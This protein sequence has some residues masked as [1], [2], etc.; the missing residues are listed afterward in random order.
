[1]VQAINA[2]TLESL[3]FTATRSADSPIR[4]QLTGNGYVYASFWKSETADANLVCLSATDEAPHPADRN[5]TRNA[6]THS[7]KESTW[8]APVRQTVTCTITVKPAAPTKRHRG[9]N[10]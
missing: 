8:Q 4:R 3:W 7:R 10:S 9:K 2:K 5:Q 6:G 1:M